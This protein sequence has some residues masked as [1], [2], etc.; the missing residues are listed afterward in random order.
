[1]VV[2]ENQSLRHFSLDKCSG[3]T[4]QLTFSYWLNNQGHMLTII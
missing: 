4:D 2:L 1:M 3:L